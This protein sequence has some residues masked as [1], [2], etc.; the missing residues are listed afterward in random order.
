MNVINSPSMAP[1][2]AFGIEVFTIDNFGIANVAI[3]PKTV[4]TKNGKMVSVAIKP[5]VY[6]DGQWT[7][8]TFTLIPGN[9]L[10]YMTLEIVVPSNVLL[11]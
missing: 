11:A 3:G 5:S 6:A 10:Q 7:N 2:D 8:L 1:S 4:N 9:Y